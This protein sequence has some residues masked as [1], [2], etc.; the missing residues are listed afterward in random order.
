MGIEGSVIETGVDKLV[1]LIK[2]R[3]RISFKDA[4][5]ELGV[6]TTVI[7][8]WVDFLEEEGLIGIE[9]KLTT[10]YLVEK[11]LSKKEVEAKAKEFTGKK[12]VFVRKAESSL[13][14]IEKQGEELKKVKGEFDKLKGEVGLELETVREDLKELEKY[15]QLKQELQKQVEEQK[16]DVKS[17][18]EELTKQVLREQRRY[19]LLISEVEKERVELTRERGEAKSIEESEK[20]LNRRLMGLKGMISAIENKISDE[21]SSIKNS[22]VHIEK[23][24]IL[25]NQI[26]KHVEEEKAVIEPLI[27]KSKEHEQKILQLQSI[28]IKK[29]SQKQ[30]KISSVKDVAS[31]VRN[32]IDKKMAV[33]TLVDKINK[34]RDELEKTLIELIK[35]AKSFQLSAKSGDV[36]K[37]MID[38]EKKFDDVDKK[39]SRFESELKDLASF[40]KK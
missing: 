21:D 37:E 27:E 15:H 26:K 22:E 9:Y 13:S 36:G 25:I 6:S 1:N 8:E 19:Q 20:I 11:K 18:I 34:D 32:F 2:Q 17:K 39:R 7:Q 40:A 31:K 33:V 12:D 23:L 24:N 5:A 16:G 38:L 28:I 14:F 3:G 35:K 10:P 29:I 4:A 30:S